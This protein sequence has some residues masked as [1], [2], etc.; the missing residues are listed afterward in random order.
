[1]KESD[2][3]Y[4]ALYNVSFYAESIFNRLLNSTCLYTQTGLPRSAAETLASIRE[5]LRLATYGVAAHVEELQTKSGV[6]DK[7]AQ[8]WIAILLAKANEMKKS[9][10]GKSPDDIS[11]ELMQ[12]LDKQSKQPFNPLL[13]I[14]RALVYQDC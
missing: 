13:N 1:M 3:G 6:K 7:I 10:A 14:K 2:S 4:H 11:A 8:H 9:Q 12:W 5:Q